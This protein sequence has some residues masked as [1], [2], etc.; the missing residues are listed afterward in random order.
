MNAAAATITTTLANHSTTTATSPSSS[1]TSLN[2]D[3]TAHYL[4]SKSALRDMEAR[5]RDQEDELDEQALT[6]QQL[7]QAKLRLEMQLEKE[8]Q[9]WSRELAEK[10]AE[11][12][13]VR[14]HTQKKIKAVEAQLEE[15]S[16]A[17]SL[18]QREKRDLERKL[19]DMLANGAAVSASLAHSQK[20]GYHGAEANGIL[21]FFKHFKS[22]LNHLESYTELFIG[23]L[24]ANEVKLKRQMLKYKQL[25]MDAQTQLEKLRESIPKQ[26]IL[27]ALK[28]QLE[29][30]EITK[31]NALKAK[32][33][34]QVELENLQQ[35]LDESNS[36]RLSV[37]F[38][39]S[40]S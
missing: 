20:A 34:L 26:S 2:L 38:S 11:M 7:E 24:S 28:A 25:A 12:D 3:P 30:S 39:S 6:I 23:A 16:E 37:S 32:Q 1:V 4:K 13:D 40:S 17:V 15:E 36:Q 10:E 21:L 19:R 8:R 18:L 31:A 9:K 27:K 33:L 5:L 29:D 35:Q 14:F 22:R